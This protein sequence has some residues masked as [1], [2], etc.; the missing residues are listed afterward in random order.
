MTDHRKAPLPESVMK[1]KELELLERLFEQEIKSAL[2]GGLHLVQIRSKIAKKMT[3]EG[4]IHLR[5]V[6]LPGRFPV[7]I[8]GYEL[9]ELGRLTYCSTC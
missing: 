8:E 3:E 2:N 5:S 6:N 4:L 7:T 9:T 1:K